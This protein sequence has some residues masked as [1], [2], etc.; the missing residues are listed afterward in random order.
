[1]LQKYGALGD[2]GTLGTY[3]FE[4]NKFILKQFLADFKC[5]DRKLQYE[6]IYPSNV[7]MKSNRS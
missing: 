2:C 5:G 6:K 1:M 4:S 7:R 3:K